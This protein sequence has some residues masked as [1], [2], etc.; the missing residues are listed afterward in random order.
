MKAVEKI[1]LRLSD[2]LSETSFAENKDENVNDSTRHGVIEKKNEE[3]IYCMTLKKGE[4]FLVL[5]AL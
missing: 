5:L 4:L 2:F 3:V 1:L